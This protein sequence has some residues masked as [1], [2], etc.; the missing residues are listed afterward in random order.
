MRIHG[1]SPTQMRMMEEMGM[2]PYM[3]PAPPMSPPY[4]V[5]PPVYPP[6]P[7]EGG[8]REGLWERIKRVF[9]RRYR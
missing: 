4:T 3:P 9:W 1:L 2:P 5:R 7:S 8:R 6:V